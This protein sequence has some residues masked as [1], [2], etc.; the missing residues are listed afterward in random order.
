MTKKTQQILS[1]NINKA[2]LDI[3]KKRIPANQYSDHL[4]DI[5]NILM[6]ALSKG[7]LYVNLESIPNTIDIKGHDWPNAH[8]KA[9]AS[10][11]W[12]KGDH[13]PI[14]RKGLLLSWRRWHLEI[15]E[16]IEEIEKRAKM[17]SR[18][19]IKNEIS[20]NIQIPKELNEEQRLA[21]KRMTEEKIILISGGPGTGKT[22]TILQMILQS[23]EADQSLRIG[24]AAPTGKATRRLQDTLKSRINSLNEQQKLK[25]S[26]IPCKTLHK[27][28][29]AKPGGF[30][31]ND[32]NQ[33]MIDILIIDEMS[34][35]D[36]S[37]MK[38]LLRALPI[39]S[40]LILIG[41]P[42][43]LPPVGSGDIW[44]QLLEGIG[45]SLPQQ[46]KI[47]LTKSYRNRGDI[48]ELSK[49]IKEEGFSAFKRKLLSLKNLS[50]VKLYRKHPP[51]LP[52]TII[53]ALNAH[54][55]QLNELTKKVNEKL[56]KEMKRSSMIEVNTTEET[57]TL[58]RCLE[59][60]MLLCPQKH[61]A[62]S[63]NHINTFLLGRE[64]KK[65]ITNWPQ[66]TPVLCGEN[67][68]EMGLA[69]GEIGV[70]IG[71]GIQRRLLFN[72]F[73]NEQK[74]VTRLIHPS[75]LKKAEPAF[76]TTI[77]KAQ[78]SESDHVILLWP[79]SS[80]SEEAEDAKNKQYI[81]DEIY[82]K[83]LIYTGITRA[84]NK[85]DIV[86]I[87]AREKEQN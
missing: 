65:G 43:Q 77:H 50:N 32:Q 41:D 55:D 62:W 20:K 45:N 40:Q 53:E 42:N 35:V 57:S 63:V 21:I 58:L 1:T 37:L 9:L 56:P 7:E 8:L 49:I 30:V 71:E 6:E 68:P 73:S 69:N 23:I 86:I 25:I 26:E 44:Y 16:T 12:D 5:V 4:E 11:G 47:S 87:E 78:G 34:M 29:L 76:A 72:V 22:S 80:I 38:A 17:K 67:Q 84:K 83:R 60:F 39:T 2:I 82:E 51:E 33:L 10:S 52:K 48:A 18:M 36:L 85:L 70:V 19:K 28:L 27:W 54:K 74:L 75:R 24:L 46:S 81:Y 31:K 64:Y 15:Q 61:G 14:I 3:L 59:N 79:A 66:G 13:S